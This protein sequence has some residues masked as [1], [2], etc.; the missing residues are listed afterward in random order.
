VTGRRT[1]LGMVMAVLVLAGTACGSDSNDETSSTTTEVGA[2]TIGDPW[3][4]TS[5]DMTDRGAC[6][7]TI[8]NATDDTTA[9]VSASVPSSVAG[10]VELH[11]TTA[12]DSS[13][14]TTMSDDTTTGGMGT[15]DTSMSGATTSDMTDSTAAGMMAMRPV[16][17][18]DVPAGETVALEPGGYHVMLLELVAPLQTGDAVQ[19]T[20]T[21][22]DGTTQTVSAEV[23]T[24]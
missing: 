22:E 19:L 20:L 4:R 14:D 23:R 13:N 6:Y 9:L 16:S 15:A 24:S 7:M 10:K 17:Q 1:A 18:I 21:F 5:P 8:E 3:C 2:I 11:E 12:A